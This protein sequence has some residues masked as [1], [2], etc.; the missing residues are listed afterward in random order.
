MNA[1]STKEVTALQQAQRELKLHA[2]LQ[3]VISAVRQARLDLQADMD[4]G[5]AGHADA[6]RA[7]IDAASEALKRRAADGVKKLHGSLSKLARSV[8]K[9]LPDADIVEATIPPLPPASQRLV[10][11]QLLAACSLS[12]VTAGHVDAADRLASALRRGSDGSCFRA[13]SCVA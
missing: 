10:R 7:A 13:R 1:D 9:S 3:P 6:C 8:E 5:H 12:L 11:Q 2:S 4:G